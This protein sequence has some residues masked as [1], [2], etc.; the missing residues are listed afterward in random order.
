MNLRLTNLLFFF[1]L[2]M[3]CFAQEKTIA[4][5]GKVLNSQNTVSNV[6]I[7]NLTTKHGTI[8]NDNGEFEINVMKND[9]LLISSIQYEKMKLIVTKNHI[10][11]KKIEIYLKPFVT[12]LDEVFL[13]GLT[14]SLN[15]DMNSTP[16][17]TLPKHNFVFKLSDLDKILPPDTHGL[18]KAPNAAKLTDPNYIE[19][20]GGIGVSTGPDKRLEAKLKLKRELKNKKAFPNK[21][22]KELGVDYFTKKLHIPIEEIDRFLA[23]CEFKNIIEEYYNNNLLEVIKI[24]QEE[25]ITYND[26]THE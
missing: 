17:D 5:S 13:H 16:N 24:L 6:H 14:G 15:S 19:G 1:V 3:N 21:I 23:Y 9:T 25:S 4:I 8:S 12:N 7:I 20:M 2:A 11:S 10:T 22:K 18:K 26:I